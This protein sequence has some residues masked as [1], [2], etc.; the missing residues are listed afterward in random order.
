MF[1]DDLSAKQEEDFNHESLDLSDGAVKRISNRPS[2]YL[3][4]FRASKSS[5]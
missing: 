3:V 2:L 1:Q 5:S 4:V